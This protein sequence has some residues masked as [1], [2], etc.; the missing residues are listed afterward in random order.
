MAMLAALVSSAEEVLEALRHATEH[1][2]TA[3]AAP[4]PQVFQLLLRAGLDLRAAL[5]L[6]ECQLKVPFLRPESV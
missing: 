4:P 2:V 3:G 5:G 1:M 6:L